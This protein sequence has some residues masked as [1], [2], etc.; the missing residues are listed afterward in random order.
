MAKYV[1]VCSPDFRNDALGG[2]IETGKLVD[3]G[4]R[5]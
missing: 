5:I 4:E 1:D 3:V 2:A